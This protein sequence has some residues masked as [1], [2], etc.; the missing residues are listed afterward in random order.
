MRGM[1]TLKLLEM[2]YS[3]IIGLVVSVAISIGDTIGIFEQ[4]RVMMTAISIQQDDDNPLGEIS[5][6]E[7]T[8]RC[9]HCENDTEVS[10]DELSCRRVQCQH[11]DEEFR[12][13]L[14]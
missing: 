12:V 13:Y 8:A 10:Q 7:V 1:R 5:R 2:R 9:P 4:K 6:F 3:L 11:C 14:G